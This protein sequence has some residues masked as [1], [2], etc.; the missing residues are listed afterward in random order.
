MDDDRDPFDDDFDEFE[1][2]LNGGA[3]DDPSD[4]DAE[5]HQLDEHEAALVL[6]DLSD[7]EAIEASFTAEGYRG[8]SVFCVDCDEEHYYPWDLLRGNLEMLLETGDLPVHEPAYAPEP[9]RYVPWEYA[10]GYVDA[11]R[12]TGVHERIDL[13]ACPRCGLQLSYELR[14]GNFCP[15]CGSTLLAAR[16]AA[17]LKEAGLDEEAI[18]RIA[19]RAGL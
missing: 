1:D 4:P 16:L 7:L 18:E 15:R 5:A 17:A 12:D 10:R 8:V 13:E 14:Q 2:D 9:D 19:R 6:Q 11:L 3:D